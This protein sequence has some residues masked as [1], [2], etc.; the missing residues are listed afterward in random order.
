MTTLRQ[1][2]NG[3]P[4]TI[5]TL[6]GTVTINE[7]D[8][9]AGDLIDVLADNDLTIH[10]SLQALNLAIFWTLYVGT[11]NELKEKNNND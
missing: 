5:L 3:A 7:Q 10:E 8:N 6:G 11:I 2:I 9:I 1:L 4:G